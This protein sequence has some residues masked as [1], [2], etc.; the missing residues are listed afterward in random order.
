MLLDLALNFVDFDTASRGRCT[1]LVRT[2]CS[3]Q[4]EKK[5]KKKSG[6]GYWQRFRDRNR[7][8]AVSGGNIDDDSNPI[9]EEL[10]N[11]SLA[12]ATLL[13]FPGRS[14][15]ETIRVAHTRYIYPGCRELVSFSASPPALKAK[16]TI[17]RD[18]NISSGDL[19]AYQSHA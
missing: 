5:K 4:E 19:G 10:R 3:T 17:V 9:T 16:T 18:L 7:A 14:A 12:S 6:K 11:G 8:R 15:S 13:T 2:K 1:D